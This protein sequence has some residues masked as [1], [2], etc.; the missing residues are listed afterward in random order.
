MSLIM[1]VSKKT[2]L[3]KEENMSRIKELKNSI[4]LENNFVKIEISRKDSEVLSVV[5][6]DT[7]ED[8]LSKTEKSCFFSVYKASENESR[9][10]L[11]GTDYTIH[12]D[13]PCEVLG[14][15]LD[16]DV[17]S[18]KTEFQ[19]LRVKAGV[20]DN[21]FTYEVLDDMAEPLERME[22]ADVKFE[23]EGDY[24]TVSISMTV[25]GVVPRIPRSTERR[26]RGVVR[27]TSG[28]SKGAKIGEVL[29]PFS[30]QCDILKEM[31]STIDPE[32]G[33]VLRTSGPWTR[34][35]SDNYN[36]YIIVL[37][38]KPEFVTK[39]DEYKA[40]GVDQFDFHQG[41]WAFWQGN[42][43]C[44]T[45]RDMTEFREKF[46][47]PL[48][49]KGITCGLHTYAHYI[50]PHCS[51]ILSDPK[52]QKDLMVLEEYILAKDIG[53]EDDVIEVVEDI[54]SLSTDHTFFSLSLP[55]LMIGNEIISFAKDHGKFAPCGRGVCGTKKVAHKKGE[56][57]Y[58]MQGKFNMFAPIPGSELF[59]EIARRTAEAYNEGGFTMIYLDAIDG[60]YSLKIDQ[61]Y[62]SAQFVHEII[63]HCNTEPTIEY[64]APC[65]SIWAAMGRTGAWDAPWQGFRGFNKYHIVKNYQ[66][67]DICHLLGMMGWYGLYPQTDGYPDAHPGNYINK[68]HHWDDTEFL[69]SLSLIHGYSMV[70]RNGLPN[71]RF[72]GLARNV[73]IF[74]KYHDVKRSGYFTEDYLAK[75]KDPDREFFLKSKGKDKWIFEEKKMAFRR[76]FDIVDTTRN[77][78]SFT[79]PF[80]AQ[81]P[82][83]RIEQGLSTMGDNK[84]LLLPMDETKQIP[85][86]YE[87][88]FA[89]TLDATKNNAL[90]FKVFGNGKKGSAVR[91][92]FVSKRAKGAAKYIVDT[93]FEGWREF[94]FIE[95]DSGERPDLPFDSRDGHFYN[96]YLHGVRLTAMSGIKIETAGDC[97]GVRIG[98]VY[99]STITYEVAKNPT[100]KVGKSEVKFEC[101]LKSTDFIEFD[102]REAF[103]LDRYGD[104]KKIWFEGELK[105]PK[106]DFKAELR[107]TSLN[108]GVINQKLTF[109]FTGNEIK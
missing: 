26:M 68:Y 106:G 56:K 39:A 88:T 11:D 23:Y 90:T 54:E 97:E 14:L 49:E 100:I 95:G 4:V 17:I 1:V 65:G 16:G 31:C 71:G 5:R 96:V 89:N 15:D 6:L 13:E 10:V 32:K 94:T 69:G 73:E 2:V 20:F 105:V 74:K 29:S 81:K 66:D 102:G 101:E 19:T 79:N 8:I 47:D 104:K 85:E 24:A 34:D 25:N 37:G 48:K 12:K 92:S 50:D 76:Y 99:G 22:F 67:A 52:W 43:K 9:E 36:N 82:F 38:F 3:F 51:D 7:K 75:L 58:H 61:Y 108:G 93:D 55:Y 41:S 91:V 27:R 35:Y 18:I 84:M 28:N 87:Y 107:A 44:T 64:A 98:N 72:P 86:S 42:F 62:Y 46:S 57:V 70:F 59:L 60:L 103:V 109:I 63:K 33:I 53:E 40:M 80:K 45:L 78:E 21:Y 77:T 30:I 83:V